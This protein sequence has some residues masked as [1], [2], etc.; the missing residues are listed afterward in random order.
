M[1]K[2]DFSFLIMLLLLILGGCSTGLDNREPKEDSAPVEIDL[3]TMSYC[4]YGIKAEIIL[5]ELKEIFQ[6]RININLFYIAE[7]KK[8]ETGEPLFRSL[9]GNSE[10]M[11]NLRQL[12]IKTYYPDKFRRYLIIRNNEIQNNNWENLAHLAGIDPQLIRRK[13]KS[14]EGAA[15]LVEN[16]KEQRTE[17]RWEVDGE[18]WMPPGASPTIYLNGVLFRGPVSLPSLAVAVNQAFVDEKLK[19]A[20]IP[21]CFHNSDCWQEGKVGHC[22]EAGTLKAWCEFTDLPRIELICIKPTDFN[23]EIDKFNKELKEI[24]PGLVIKKVRSD[25]PEGIELIEKLDL[26]FLPSYIFNQSLEKAEN[27]NHLLNQ[28]LIEKRGNF[29]LMV[30][31]MAREGVFLDRDWK[32][33]QLDIFVMSQC[34]FGPETY[35]QLMEKRDQGE[36]PSEVNLNLNY[37]AELE[38]N[39]EDKSV[40]F[41]SYHGQ[42]EVDEDIR[43]LCIKKY[44]PDKFAEYLRLRNEDIKST[45]W[46]KPAF[47]SGVNPARVIACVYRSGKQLLFKNAGLGTDLK[48][49]TSPTFLWENQYL[50][51]NPEK[52]KSLPGLEDINIDELIGSCN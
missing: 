26:T 25:S 6:D 13:I 16:I 33:N 37:I 47:G 20:D 31:N 7:L 46:E 36:I 29:Y 17:G 18:K 49:K 35:I 14:G 23:V 28:K 27:F 3:F 1:N 45:L 22:R 21:E 24:F 43:Q 5:M 38:I 40:S 11:E 51:Y 34:P 9:H 10:L 48:I 12:L 44:Y 32:P 30:F 42:P 52:L 2:N 15:L 19:I 50:F 8:S 41:S 39:P 4:P